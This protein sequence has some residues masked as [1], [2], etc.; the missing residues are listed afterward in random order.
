MRMSLVAALAAAALAWLPSTSNAQTGDHPVKIGIL[1]DASGPYKDNQG[2]GD[3]VAVSIALEDFGKQLLGKD[4]Q[5]VYADHQNKSDIAVNLARQWY[6]VDGVDVIMGLGNSA[7]AL[8]VQQLAKEK[9]KIDIATAA[10]S[11]DLIGKACSPTGFL[12]VHDTYA[13]ATSAA[14]ALTKAG[15]NTWFFLTADYAFGHALERDAAR[16]VEASGGKVLGNVNHPAFAPDLSSYL[17]QAQ[18]SGAKVIGL[19]NAGVDTVN[20]IKQAAEFHITGDGKQRV[21]AML[22]LITDVKSAGLEAAQGLTVT[23]AYY[24]DLDDQTRAFASRF[25]KEMHRPPTM[26]HAGLYSAVMHYL[27]AVKAAGTTD[28]SAV[29]AKMRELPI[30]DMM[31][32]NARIREDGRVMRNMYLFEAKKPSESKGD[33][34]LLKKV[35]VVNAEDAAAPLS[36]SECPSIKK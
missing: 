23:L 1:H 36:E 7:V 9:H 16:I 8:A 13:V 15:Y 32:R 20:S 26:Y 6:D 10:S 34:D 21:A 22:F 30:N 17:L 18:A 33:W 35:G 28:T 12:W 14:R 4:I 27:K 19:A 31:T 3:N 5:V 2:M 24:W 29:V 11:S 25:E